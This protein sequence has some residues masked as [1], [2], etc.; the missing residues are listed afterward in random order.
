M[1]NLGSTFTTARNAKYT[2]PVVQNTIISL[3]ENGIQE[4][5]LAMSS[6]SYWSLMADETEDVSNMEQA[7]VCARFVP[8]YEVYEDLLGFVAVAKMDAQTFT[9]VLLSTLSSGELIWLFQLVK[10]MMVHL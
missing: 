9:D 8:N 6:S 4:K 1:V 5:V 7:S 2:S 10:V 3:C